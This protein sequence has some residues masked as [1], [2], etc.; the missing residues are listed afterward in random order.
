VAATSRLADDTGLSQLPTRYCDSTRSGNIY[1]PLTYATC[2][3]GDPSVVAAVET[4]AAAFR[5]CLEA[6]ASNASCPRASAPAA[7]CFVQYRSCIEERGIAAFQ[8]DH[9][10]SDSRLSCPWGRDVFTTVLSTL[11]SPSG[12]VTSYNGSLL[13]DECARFIGVLAECNVSAM[14]L[15]VATVC[16]N[17]TQTLSS[18]KEQLAIAATGGSVRRNMSESE[19][20]AGPPVTGAPSALGRLEIKLQFQA[21]PATCSGGMCI[22]PASGDC[23]CPAATHWPHPVQVFHSVWAALGLWQASA[24]EN[25]FETPFD[26]QLC[27]PHSVRRDRRQRNVSA[28]NLTTET[29]TFVLSRDGACVTPNPVTEE[30]TCSSNSVNHSFEVPIPKASGGAEAGWLT[31]C[32]PPTTVA[33]LR[34]AETHVCANRTMDDRCRICDPNGDTVVVPIAFVNRTTRAASPGALTICGAGPDHDRD[35][36]AATFTA[37]VAVSGGAAGNS[38]GAHLQNAALLMSMGCATEQARGL[39]GDEALVPF[40]VGDTAAKEVLGLCVII[41]GVFVANVI[42]YASCRSYKARRWAQDDALRSNAA[43]DAFGAAAVTDDDE[44]SGGALESARATVDADAEDAD[45]FERRQKLRRSSVVG[46]GGLGR[47]ISMSAARHITVH[48]Q[49]AD[50]AAAPASRPHIG[51]NPAAALLPEP[52]QT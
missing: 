44:D 36:V 34:N 15:S 42:L 47:K 24:P 17:A 50:V 45:V 4:C 39:G 52:P 13:Q 27:Y 43:E 38:V 40:S 1:A 21:T 30:C 19:S 41:C 26:L 8:A 31:L 28:L 22:L 25:C 51:G 3:A 33:F 10:A 11:G 29:G 2:C 32:L 49:A 48:S 35:R 6:E 46:T 5:A 23:N 18:R 37:T 12:N 7:A 16:E 9:A 14:P 20:Q